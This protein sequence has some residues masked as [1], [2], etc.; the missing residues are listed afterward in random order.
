MLVVRMAL[1]LDRGEPQASDDRTGAGDEEAGDEPERGADLGRRIETGGKCRGDADEPLLL[2]R[3]VDRSAVP[4][5]DIERRPVKPP[6]HGVPMPRAD[7]AQQ[8]PTPDPRETRQQKVA[9]PHQ[10]CH[11]R[12]VEFPSRDGIF[13][14]DAH[15]ATTGR[16]RGDVSGVLAGITRRALSRFRSATAHIGIW[17][18]NSTAECCVC[19]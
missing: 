8:Q 11:E 5:G 6:E 3:A 15:A 17:W 7:P 9:P 19:R 2:E 14:D 13:S 4:L 1:L 12:V 16:L 10:S 18:R